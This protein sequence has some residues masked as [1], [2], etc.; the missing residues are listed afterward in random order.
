MGSHHGTT[1]RMRG[2]TTLALLLIHGGAQPLSPPTTEE[3]P[4]GASY[5]KSFDCGGSAKLRTEGS[6]TTLTCNGN[7]Y[8][9]EPCE[10]GKTLNLNQMMENGV[11]KTTVTCDD[12]SSPPL[13]PTFCPGFP[14][15]DNQGNGGIETHG[16]WPGV[17]TCRNWP[18]RPYSPWP[19]M[20]WP[21]QGWPLMN[22][23]GQQGYWPGQKEI[24]P[25]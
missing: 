18:F 22:W 19:L 6:E 15:C 20:N 9:L 1:V 23:P 21:G 25:G 14:F 10:D 3:Q 5:P 12:P 16:S 13:P 4:E 11:G 2:P 17:D 7:T 8:P 24:W